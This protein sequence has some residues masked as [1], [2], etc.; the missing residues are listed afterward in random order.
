M[1]HG[2]ADMAE[3]VG[4]MNYGEHAKLAKA[5]QERRVLEHRQDDDG[6]LRKVA[7]QVADERQAVTVLAAGHGEVGHEHV[8]RR[9][10]Q[11]LDQLR[12]L[13]GTGNDLNAGELEQR[14]LRAEQ[15]HRM[16]V[17][18]YD[19]DW[20]LLHHP[21]VET[22][23]LVLSFCSPARPENPVIPAHGFLDGQESSRL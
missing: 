16:I 22:F 23:L 15:D 14:M 7:A 11:R 8:A 4:F 1:L 3:V 9:G 12:G 13:A 20:L 19:P 17:R 10:L 5:L 6:N 2:E 21:S 18:N